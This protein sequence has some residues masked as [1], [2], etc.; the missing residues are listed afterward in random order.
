MR[1]LTFKTRLS[2]VTPS[3][4]EHFPIF[5]LRGGDGFT[6]AKEKLKEFLLV[7]RLATPS[8]LVD[9]II[10]QLIKILIDHLSY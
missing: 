1:V 8:R 5:F 2:T 10:V 9:L 4:Q 3:P 7:G 6:H